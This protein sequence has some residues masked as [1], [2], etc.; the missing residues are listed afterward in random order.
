MVRVP[1]GW[2][3]H[4]PAG[5][6]YASGAGQ[7]LRPASPDMSGYNR[8]VTVDLGNDGI[9]PLVTFSAAGVAAAFCGPNTSGESWSL[10]QC[11][12]GTSVGQLDPAQCIVYVG[13]LPQPVISPVAQYAVTGSLEGGGSQFGLG[14]IGFA[15]GWFVLAVWTGGT[16]GTTAQLRIT[17]S[18]TVP[19]L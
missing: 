4:R 9:A 7:F 17:G 1:R 19:S 6:Q 8:L 10:D 18:K 14:G 15:F 3:L 11:F 12:L 5:S 16:P 13:P 2:Q